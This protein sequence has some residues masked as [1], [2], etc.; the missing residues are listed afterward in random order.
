MAQVQVLG[1]EQAVWVLTRV[2]P[3]DVSR[4]IK[5]DSS[6]S[7]QDWIQRPP[8]AGSCSEHS[9][10]VRCPDPTLKCQRPQT[11][12]FCLSGNKV[13]DNLFWL[14]S[15][16]SK[17]NKLLVELQHL[18]IWLHSV[19]TVGD[20]SSSTWPFLKKD[21]ERKKENWVSPR[22]PPQKSG[23]F[24][25]A[26]EMH[27]LAVSAMMA[28]CDLYWE[29]EEELLW[30]IHDAI[31]PYKLNKR[32]AAF[33][34]ASADE[35]HVRICNSQIAMICKQLLLFHIQ[36][37]ILPRGRTGQGPFFVRSLLMTVSYR[38]YLWSFPW[39]EEIVGN[40]GQKGGR[41][42]QTN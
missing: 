32:A 4:W 26:E 15:L 2:Q 31:T 20:F 28:D 33:S 5:Y 40:R 41:G 27:F 18:H 17:W 7:F 30:E 37:W 35:D 16:C 25:R 14:L 12:T 39:E 3:S 38:I 36:F 21:K 42:Q 9:L 13:E 6:A 34:Q 10:S 8:L 19:Q 23:D 1:L 22:F 29:M 11:L 24:S